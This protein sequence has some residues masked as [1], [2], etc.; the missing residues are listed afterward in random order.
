MSGVLSRYRLKKGH[1]VIHIGW[2]QKDGL[3]RGCEKMSIMQGYSQEES[4][5]AG[6][7]GPRPAGSEERAWQ[8]RVSGRVY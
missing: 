7:T 6:Y 3:R 2:K 4:G 5:C 8:K 1:E